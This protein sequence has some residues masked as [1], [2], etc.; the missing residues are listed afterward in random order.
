MYIPTNMTPTA[1]SAMQVLQK[2]TRF[3]H[4]E[5]LLSHCAAHAY[6][7][8]RTVTHR[9]T[10]TSTQVGDRF[11]AEHAPCVYL[12]SPGSTAA[13]AVQAALQRVVRLVQQRIALAQTPRESH[14]A[15]FQ[16]CGHPHHL[17]SECFLRRVTRAYRA[18]TST[19][20]LDSSVSCRV[21]LRSTASSEPSHRL[22]IR[23]K[24]PT[25]L[26]RMHVDMA[27][28]GWLGGCR[29]L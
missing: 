23:A 8:H 22:C 1:S 27:T 13:C 11:V 19:T 18:L 4:R 16:C 12:T 6:A 15:A 3:L 14:G 28:S 7:V 20:I 10:F 26:P 29:A 2:P 21:V 9:P 24:H 25:L 5:S 17:I